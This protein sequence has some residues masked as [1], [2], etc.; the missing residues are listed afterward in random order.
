L[1][2]GMSCVCLLKIA[3][4]DRHLQ[5]RQEDDESECGE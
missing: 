2:H 3:W 4:S 1:A 5:E